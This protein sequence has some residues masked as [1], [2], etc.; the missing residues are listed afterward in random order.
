MKPHIVDMLFYDRI[1]SQATAI[2]SGTPV[3]PGVV[4]GVLI[5]N[6]DTLERFNSKESNHRDHLSYIFCVDIDD[7]DDFATLQDATGFIS[8][9][10]STNSWC[11]VQAKSEGIPTIIGVNAILRSTKNAATE[12]K[13]T[14]TG[15]LPGASE[16]QAT[17]GLDIFVGSKGAKTRLH[18]GELVTID[19]TTGTIYRGPCAASRAPIPLAFDFIVEILAD[20]LRADPG[21]FSYDAFLCSDAYSEKRNRIKGLLKLDA[22]ESTLGQSGS[23]K[24]WRIPAIAGTVHTAEGVIKARMA[25]SRIR[26]DDELDE[27]R[28]E[29]SPNPLCGVGLLR[30]E[31]LF[32]TT[33]ELDDLRV[34]ILGRAIFDDVERG[35]AYQNYAEFVE[36]EYFTLLSA[37]RGGL[38]VVRTLCMPNNKL[39]S[40]HH[41]NAAFA[42]RQGKSERRI[43]D[44]VAAN[45][46]ES[47]T[48]HGLRGIRLH[49]IDPRLAKSELRGYLRAISR[50]RACDR[51][52]RFVLLLSMVTLTDEVRTFSD[53]LSEEAIKL[54]AE[55]FD[56]PFVELAIMIE[57]MNAYVQ[58]EDFTT[59]A[60]QSCAL[61]G[62]LFGGN[63]LTAATLNMNRA[64]SVKSLIP[65]YRA[66]GL[67]GEDPFVRFDETVIR[68]IGRGARRIKAALGDSALIGVGGEQTADYKSIRALDRESAGWIDFVSTSPDRV[69]EHTVRGAFS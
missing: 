27:L 9:N 41:G 67:L 2:G 48:F 52:Q 34:I 4:T 64:D 49:M 53:W 1:D 68:V 16:D 28:I 69:I 47:E 46:S 13:R 62:F 18:D 57:T 36:A 35:R 11:V 42:A 19:G 37:N 65:K 56:V 5:T 51:S 43:L 32:R 66:I 54:N 23:G 12:Y 33:R 50:V 58:I 40:D 10:H 63:D 21:G 26:W 29:L 3:H 20:R 25:G 31:R 14:G 55:G 24:P 61:T 39:F 17:D 22:V 6:C 38:S 7:V 60:N 15:N 30:T 45:I 44:V 8:L 59:I